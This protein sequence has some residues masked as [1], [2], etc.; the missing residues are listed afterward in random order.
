MDD[1]EKRMLA[2]LAE[3]DDM[4]QLVSWLNI[5]ELNKDKSE[6]RLNYEIDD[7]KR[8]LLERSFYKSTLFVKT[9]KKRMSEIREEIT[10]NNK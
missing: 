1:L 6:L 8:Q 2:A 5:S 3:T 10:N 7:T 9:I 4:E